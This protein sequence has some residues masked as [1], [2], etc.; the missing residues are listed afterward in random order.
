M[1]LRRILQCTLYSASD[2]AHT[3]RISRNLAIWYIDCKSVVNLLRILLIDAGTEANTSRRTLN[4]EPTPLASA[5]D[6]DMT[7]GAAA[8]GSRQGGAKRQ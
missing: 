3:T 7:Q 8:G 4:N 6:Q 2:S 5:V 1:Q